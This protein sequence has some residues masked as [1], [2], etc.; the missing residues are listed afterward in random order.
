LLR[1]QPIDKVL[2]AKAER[3]DLRP[4]HAQGRRQARLS[5]EPIVPDDRAGSWQ[6]GR[7]GLT[8]RSLESPR[9]FGVRERTIWTRVPALA[10]VNTLSTRPWQWFRL[11][12]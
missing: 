12:K 4:G 2:A 8:R 9:C 3:R 5:H 6:V 10:R 7:A 11:R 1:R